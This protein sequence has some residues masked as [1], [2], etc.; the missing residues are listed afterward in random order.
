M[1]HVTDVSCPVKLTDQSILGKALDLLCTE[2]NG[3]LQKSGNRWT[4]ACKMPSRFG[5]KERVQ[6]IFFENRAGVMVPRADTYW[7]PEE[8]SRAIDRIAHHYN[9]IS[10]VESCKALRY[11]TSTRKHER[12]AIILARR[13]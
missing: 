4:F 10:V 9:S 2:L 13:Y 7:S 12:Q 8:V 5:Q 3:T 11:I 6:Q 1:S